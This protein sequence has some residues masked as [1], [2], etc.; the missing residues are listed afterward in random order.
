MSRCILALDQGTTS[1][2]AIVFDRAGRARAM[3]Q[4]EFRQRIFDGDG[5]LKRFVNV[6]VN[7]EDVR[8]LSGLATALKDGDEVSIVPSTPSRIAASITDL[9][10]GPGVSWSAVIGMTP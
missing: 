6:Y 7:G 5:G 8:F 3:A 2:R 10:M 4:R 1:S 9:A